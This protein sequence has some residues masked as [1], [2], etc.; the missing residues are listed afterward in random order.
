[1]RP[2]RSA[3]KA[4]GSTPLG[5]AG[6]GP[7]AVDGAL[8]VEDLVDASHRLEREGRDRG[9]GPAA[10][11]PRGDVGQLKELPPSV[12][13][14]ER[15]GRGPGRAVGGVDPAESRTGVGPG[16][17]P[18]S[19]WSTP[20]RPAR[21]RL[22]CSPR[23]P[24]EQRKSA[25]GGV[26]PAKGRSQQAWAY[27]RPVLVLPR[28]S[29][30]T[31]VSSPCR[32]SVAMTWA[33]ITAWSGGRADPGSGP[34]QALV[35]QGRGAELDALAGAALRLAVER[36]VAGRTSRTAASRGS[37]APPGRTAWDGTARAAG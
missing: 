13:P 2:S 16:S 14:A 1:M 32:R 10:S 6:V 37:S 5:L 15:G 31:V 27:S 22:G 11:G 28:A 4:W 24:G 17:S 9:R 3:S 12:R 25:A 7:H 18:G 20:P 36:R 35:G 30:G 33:S 21:C 29:T 26:G 19:P 23:R 8:E 34:G